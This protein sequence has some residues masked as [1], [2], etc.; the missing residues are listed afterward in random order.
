MNEKIEQIESTDVVGWNLGKVEKEVKYTQNN[1]ESLAKN[2]GTLSIDDICKML[3]K[4]KVEKTLPNK[5]IIQTF[6]WNPN[7]LGDVYKI[8]DK[9]KDENNLG[10]DSLVI[11][12][13]WMPTWLLPVISH[14]LHPVSTAV[15]YPQGNK[16]LWLSGFETSEKGEWE[17]LDFTIEDKGFYT[18][19]EFSLTESAIDLDKTMKSLI[20]PQIEMWK[21]VVISG[22]W[23]IAIAT[24]LA[25]TYAHKVP[26]VANFQPWTWAVVSISHDFKNPL[27]KIINLDQ[28]LTDNNTFLVPVNKEE[29]LKKLENIDTND[30]IE[31][32]E[33]HITAINFGLWLK[34]KEKIEKNPELKNEINKLLSESN[35]SYE[36]LDNKDLYEISKDYKYI[37]TW[38]KEKNTIEETRKSIILGVKSE[39]MEKF[40]S[41][42]GKIIWEELDIFPH[43]TLATNSTW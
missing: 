8:V 40:I 4:E 25:E 24:A 38:T 19:V 9:Y 18:L 31:K 21:W 27:W 12:D 11:I 3:W 15:N 34:I 10:V 14:A 26:F 5:K 32:E 39:W 17:N 23:P 42:L 22:R 1:V 41:E 30:Y 6:D 37:E 28:K 33:F 20:V 43:I 29:V 2:T 16:F 7:E 36:L 13:W 35:F